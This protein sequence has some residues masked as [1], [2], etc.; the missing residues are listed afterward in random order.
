MSSLVVSSQET[1]I[2]ISLEIFGKEAWHTIDQEAA[3]RYFRFA[4]KGRVRGHM[5]AQVFLT[6]GF[7]TTL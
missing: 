7:M 2:T 1:G 3:L 4:R 5:R 6:L